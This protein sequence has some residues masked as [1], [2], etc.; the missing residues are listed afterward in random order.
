MNAPLSNR[1]HALHHV[2]FPT[3]NPLQANNG[4]I[5]G[6]RRGNAGRGDA[7]AGACL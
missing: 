4:G 1:P 5:Q 3:T 6:L 7:G 2:N